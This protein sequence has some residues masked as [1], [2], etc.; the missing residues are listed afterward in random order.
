MAL[1]Q[2]MVGMQYSR[3]HGRTKPATVIERYVERIGWVA[4]EGGGRKE[5]QKV[6]GRRNVKNQVEY[7]HRTPGKN[8][9]VG[10]AERKRLTE[11]SRTAGKGP[12]RGKAG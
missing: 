1:T 3:N 7:A 8:A 9:A 6:G 5:T 4:A 11:Y 10:V 12:Q 2:H